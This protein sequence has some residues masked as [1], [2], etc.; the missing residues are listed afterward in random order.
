MPQF[1]D[2]LARFYG[3]AADQGWAAAEGA[4]GQCGIATG[5]RVQD[6]DLPPEWKTRY[7]DSMF[8]DEFDYYEGD[9][10]GLIDRILGPLKLR[11]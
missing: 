5:R 11:D 4:I 6:G 1:E 8:E 9:G 2:N 10:E 7:A 3:F